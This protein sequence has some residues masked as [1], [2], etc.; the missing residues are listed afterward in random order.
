MKL[1]H[2]SFGLLRPSR[3]L[4]TIGRKKWEAVVGSVR[5]ALGAGYVRKA[6]KVDK[7][8]IHAASFDD[9]KLGRAGLRWSK[10]KDRFWREIDETVVVAET[11]K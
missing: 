4:L 5:E 3:E 11:S 9:E 10:P 7:E 2:G 8:A 6:E 1:T